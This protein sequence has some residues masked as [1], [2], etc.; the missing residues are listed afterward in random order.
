MRKP[1]LK[2]IGLGFLIFITVTCLIGVWEN[3]LSPVIDSTTSFIIRL[4]AYFSSAYGDT[5]YF[6]AA[7]GFYER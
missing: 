3:D 6:E 5:I 2:I 1:L 4:L 7:K